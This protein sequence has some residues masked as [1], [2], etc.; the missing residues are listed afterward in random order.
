MILWRWNSFEFQKI[1]LWRSNL[2]G[3]HNLPISTTFTERGCLHFSLNLIIP[4][5]STACCSEIGSLTSLNASDLHASSDVRE[6]ISLQHALLTLRQFPGVEIKTYIN[7]MTACKPAALSEWACKTMPHIFVLE[8][9]S[10][11][12]KNRWSKQ[13]TEVSTLLFFLLL[14]NFSSANVVHMRRNFEDRPPGVDSSLAYT[15]EKAESSGKTE[16]RGIVWM[17]RSYRFHQ[18]KSEKLVN[19]VRPQ[20]FRFSSRFQFSTS[21]TPWLAWEKFSKMCENQ[22]I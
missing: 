14:L 22:P 19:P 3:P 2:V 15:E 13:N 10:D 12:W 16:S 9:N 5:L 6:P 17:F 21:I 8:K 11:Y 7:Y 1:R 18:P 4:I 20:C